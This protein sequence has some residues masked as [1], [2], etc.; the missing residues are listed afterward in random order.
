MSRY[1]LAVTG[2]TFDHFHAGHAA[3]LRA[4]L[5]CSK[6]LL[7]GI[8]S[9]DYV[10]RLK[11]AAPGIES[12]AV[13]EQH[14][15]KFLTAEGAAGRTTVAKID[16]VFYPTEWESL[17]IEAIIATPDTQGGAVQINQARRQRRLSLL[18]IELVPLVRD[19][20]GRVLSST[21]L[22]NNSLSLLDIPAHDLVL[23]EHERQWF[24]EPFGTLVPDIG[25]LPPIDYN[26]VVTVGD[27]ITQ[28][29][30]QAGHHPAISVI[31]FKVERRWTHRSVV[32]LG[33]SGQ[34]PVV[35]AF[36]PPGQLTRELFTAVAAAAGAVN[37]T[38]QQIILVHGEEDLAVL[39]L[40]LALPTGYT[41]LYGQPQ[42][43]V[44]YVPVSAASQ[45]RA[46][47]LL[48]KFTELSA[49][50]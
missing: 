31:D 27:V 20:T 36:N 40:I 25:A 26:A 33:F 19:N 29:S 9:D 6:E 12:Y 44:V 2:G 47:T 37:T 1:K 49:D 4:A 43:G 15:K 48:Q 18:A 24:H 42:Q 32:E 17:P 28:K 7:V 21:R 23:P 8:T 38:R 34:E 16:T 3:L 39:P 14:I 5:A 22:R 45:A 11:P 10:K 41:L 50:H 35:E 13:R 46:R 30:L